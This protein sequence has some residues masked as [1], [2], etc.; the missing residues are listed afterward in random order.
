MKFT[1]FLS[2]IC[3]NLFAEAETAPLFCFS[4]ASSAVHLVVEEEDGGLGR[5]VS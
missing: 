1:I 4:D 5:Y 2:Q 3:A